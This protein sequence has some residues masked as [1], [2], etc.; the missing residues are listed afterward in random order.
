MKVSSA[1]VASTGVV[2]DWMPKG[3]DAPVSWR[4]R[5]AG[6]LTGKKMFKYWVGVIGENG[7][8]LCSVVCIWALVSDIIYGLGSGIGT[9]RIGI[10][11]RELGIGR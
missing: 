10:G 7:C 9:W 5:P 6:L 2:A 8:G 4:Y 11:P 3:S 1:W